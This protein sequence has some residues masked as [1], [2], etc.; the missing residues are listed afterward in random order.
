MPRNSSYSNFDDLTLFRASLEEFRDPAPGFRMLVEFP[1]RGE[2]L[3]I[4]VAVRIADGC[5]APLASSECGPGCLG[6]PRRKF[7]GPPSQL[8]EWLSPLNHSKPFR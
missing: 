5:H 7:P 8:R 1:R 3:G 6:E 4:A 2:F